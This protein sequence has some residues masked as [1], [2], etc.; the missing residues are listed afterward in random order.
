[1]AQV[2]NSGTMRMEING[3]ELYVEDQ[4]DK[5]CPTVL[6]MHHGLGSVRAWRG[7]SPALVDAGYRVIAYDRL[8]YGNSPARPALDVPLFGTDLADLRALLD[9]LVARRVAMVGHSD[10]GTLALYFA[11]QYP[12]LV[13]CLVTIAAHIYIEP[14][15]QPGIEGIRALF[16]HDPRFREGLRRAHGEKYTSVFYNW[17]NGWHRPESLGWDMRPVLS[18]IACPV[19]VVQGVYDEHATP[20]HARDIAGSIPGAELWLVEQAAH[21]LP[22]ENIRV[23]NNRLLEF[24]T[25]HCTSWDL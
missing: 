18:K 19:L 8:G 13:C 12:E 1:M 24:L 6:L 11:A 15:M 20:Q 2:I 7:Q 9:Q 16:E 4:G 17:F 3:H 21:M 10:G 25:A 14:K 23:F 5:S 22:Q